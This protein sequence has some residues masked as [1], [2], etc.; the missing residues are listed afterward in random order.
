MRGGDGRLAVC[1]EFG[2]FECFVVAVALES[3]APDAS[4][5]DVIGAVVVFEYGLVYAVA[6]HYGVFPWYERAFGF[7]ADG[8]AHAEDVVFV[9]EWEVH[10]VGA[11]FFCYVAIP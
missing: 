2:T 4:E 1:R 7:V 8:Y 3:S 10:V 9:F 11:V 6:A 5:V